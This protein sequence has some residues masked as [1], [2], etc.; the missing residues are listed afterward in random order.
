[1]NINGWCVY[2]YTVN[3]TMISPLANQHSYGKWSFIVDLPIKDG[4]VSQLCQFTRGYTIGTIYYCYYIIYFYAYAISTIATILLN[5]SIYILYIH[6]RS[7]II[8]LLLLIYIFCY[9]YYHLYHTHA[10][11]RSRID[12]IQMVQIDRQIDIYIQIQT[13]AQNGKRSFPKHFRT[14]LLMFFVVT[15][16]VIRYHLIPLI[17][18]ALVLK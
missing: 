9:Y 14:L 18:H 4:G 3:S 17:H 5:N 8:L 13:N 12:G 11:N 16:I 7:I 15:D 10:I 2:I 6:A 1:M